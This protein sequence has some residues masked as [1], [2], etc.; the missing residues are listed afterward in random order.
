MSETGSG[1]SAL[2]ADSE[3]DD[4]GRDPKGLTPTRDILDATSG[5]DPEGGSFNPP[6]GH[7]DP[8]VESDDEETPEKS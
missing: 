8:L 6:G 1:S 5:V 4:P 2:G 3:I 7:L